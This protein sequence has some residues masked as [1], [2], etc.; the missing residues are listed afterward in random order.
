MS[1]VL[2]IDPGNIESAIALIDSD[3]YAL[4]YFGKHSND[5][6][7][8]KVHELAKAGQISSVAIE[9]LAGY[10]MPVGREVF[11]TCEWVGRFAE[12]F[13]QIYHIHTTFYYRKDVKLHLCGQMRAKDA[14]VRM[15]LVERFAKHDLK[16]GKGTKANPDFFYGVKADVW[17]AIAVGVLHIDTLKGV[18]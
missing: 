10:G 6:I 7:R 8:E 9:R 4:V 2:A 14:N 5:E 17:A 16:N 13:E 15:A 3:T 18:I 12:I 1:A 11:E